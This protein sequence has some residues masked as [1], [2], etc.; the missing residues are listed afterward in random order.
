MSLIAQHRDTILPILFESLERN[1][2]GHWN[3]AINELTGNVRRMFIEMDPELFEECQTRYMDKE[4][5]LN[6]KLKQRELAWK[7]LEA[8]ASQ[9]T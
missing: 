4:A 9:A 8:I 2:Q 5:I 1:I 6:E 3:Q 7:K